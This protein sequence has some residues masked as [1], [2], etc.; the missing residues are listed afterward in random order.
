MNS[1]LMDYEPG[2]TN[3]RPDLAEDYS[4]SDDGK[5]FTFHLRKGVKFHNGRELTTEDVKYSIERVIN[6]QTQSSGARFFSPLVD[7]DEAEMRTVR[8]RRIAIIFQE[9]MT[10]LNP[11]MPI[12]RQLG[13]AL[14]NGG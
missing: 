5:V 6:P 9:P 1:S 13:E 3:L 4:I 11:I 14:R 12:G 7:F 2:A 8:R 10:S